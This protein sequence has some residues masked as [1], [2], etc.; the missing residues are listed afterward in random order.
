MS[1]VFCRR[2]L[3]MCADARARS[4]KHS[5]AS[6]GIRESHL[7][8]SGGGRVAAAGRRSESGQESHAR[9]CDALAGVAALAAQRELRGGSRGGRAAATGVLEIFE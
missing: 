3:H 6:R 5:E 8:V 9:S 2:Q 4:G 1:L 7:P